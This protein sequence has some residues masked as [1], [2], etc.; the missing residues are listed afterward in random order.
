MQLLSQ[1]SSS[2]AEGLDYVLVMTTDNFTIHLETAPAVPLIRFQ[3]RF[4]SHPEG[5][6]VKPGL[7]TGLTKTAVYRKLTRQSWGPTVVALVAFAVCIQL[8]WSVHPVQSP[9]FTETHP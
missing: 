2:V 8:F 4:N 9:G 7:W 3:H 5:V 6:S 1:H